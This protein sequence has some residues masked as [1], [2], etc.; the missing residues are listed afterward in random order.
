MQRKIWPHLLF[1]F[2]LLLA[3]CRS[4][5]VTQR[6]LQP[7]PSLKPSSQ[8]TTIV[9]GAGQ[10]TVQGQ[11]RTY[12]L[13]TPQSH[14]KNT[15]LPLVIAFHGYGSQGKDLAHS[16]GLN[17]LADRA[18]FVVVYPDGLDRR[19]H[20]GEAFSGPDDVAFTAELIQHVSQIRA[21]NQQRIYVV[22]V[23]N[24]G[25]L[26]QQLA[27]VSHQ[28]SL[29]IA[30]FASVAATLPQPLEATCRP[31]APIPLVMINGTADQKVPWQGG[32]RPY[33]TILSVPQTVEF[34]R[35]RNGCR[36]NAPLQQRPTSQV[37]ITR[38][39]PCQS[40]GEV[41]LVTLI[42]A[43]HGFP[44]G[45]NGNTGLID[46][47]QEVWHFFQRHSSQHST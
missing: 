37:T 6:Q 31:P 13:H 44:R 33:G 5:A 47:S 46:G 20:V 38:Y 7:N 39:T 16:S 26:V 25:F 1:L 27:C 34:W 21:I 23:S 12:W 9:D 10:L 22:G 18:G 24:G 15:A 14:Q 43:G 36:A 45:G 8:T 41:E 17:A 35:Q 28:R 42:G 40:Q 30:A 29:P 19:W 32:V 3:G 11:T 2:M 4:D